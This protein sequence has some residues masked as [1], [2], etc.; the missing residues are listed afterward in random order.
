VAVAGDKV[1]IDGK[2]RNEGEMQRKDDQKVSSLV[3]TFAVSGSNC[4][5]TYETGG[6]TEKSGRRNAVNGFGRKQ[7]MQR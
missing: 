5:V 3:F 6:E 4:S 7:G 2:R 1:I